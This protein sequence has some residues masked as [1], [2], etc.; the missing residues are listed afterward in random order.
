MGYGD[1]MLLI[2]TG[3]YVLIYGIQSVLLYEQGLIMSV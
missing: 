2:I 1:L 3:D